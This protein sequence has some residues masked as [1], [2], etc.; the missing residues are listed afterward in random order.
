[1]KTKLFLI[2]LLSFFSVHIAAEELG[3]LTSEQ[4]LTLQKES[5]ALVIDIRT[6]KE[7][8]ATGVIPDSHK[9]QFFSPSGNYDAKKWL[10][11]LNQ[12]KTEENQ[13]IIL[14]CRSGGRSGK[15]GSLLAKELEMNNIHHLSNGIT[16][17]IKAGNKIKKDCTNTLACK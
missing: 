16:S 17:W 14:V 5:N 15:V 11:D 9:L 8:G 13:A 10:A 3:Q 1:M 12:L 7:W 6:E 2:L 4:L